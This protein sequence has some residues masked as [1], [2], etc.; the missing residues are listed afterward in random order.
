M[1]KIV[2]GFVLVALVLVTG[3]FLTN[4]P[5]SLPAQTLAE[6]H[7]EGHEADHHHDHEQ[8]NASSTEDLTA[9]TEVSV[10]IRDFT[11][12]KANITIK[13]GTKVTWTN[14]DA[15]QHNVMKEHDDDQHAHSAPS[16][17]ELKPDVFAGPMLARGERYSFTFS[18]PGAYPYHCAPHPT[19]KAS[20]TVIE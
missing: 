19:M 2:A 12:S 6:H 13:K 7:E 20:I 11:Y 16:K 14:Q 17:D 9:Q 3:I 5:D 1:K 10:D 18:K 4:R 15:I 8:V